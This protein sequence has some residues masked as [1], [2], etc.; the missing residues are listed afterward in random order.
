LS[1]ILLLGNIVL[2]VEV[3]T[4]FFQQG[5]LQVAD[6]VDFK[7]LDFGL[8]LVGCCKSVLLDAI[9]FFFPELLLKLDDCKD[10][11]SVGLQFFADI[12][13]V[14]FKSYVLQFFLVTLSKVAKLLKFEKDLCLEL[15]NLVEALVDFFFNS[16]DIL[17]SLVV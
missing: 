9:L 13:K 4:V 15:I 5:A 17:L 8:K 14:I 2:L 10:L 7:V 11:F 3:C 6:Q 1:E 12:F 16:F